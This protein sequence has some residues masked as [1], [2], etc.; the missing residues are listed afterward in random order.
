M[1]QSLSKL[2][3]HLV[4]ST[5]Y[6]MAWLDRAIRYRVHA[7]L[8]SVL[9][10]LASPWVVVGGVEDHVHALFD[11]GK[12]TTPVTFVEIA[13]RESSKY[14][15]TLGRKYSEFS[16]QRGYGM[17]S[18]S[19]FH[20]DRVEAYV[21]SQEAHHRLQS[22]QDEYRM[23]LRAHQIEFDERFVW[24]LPVSLSLTSRCADNHLRG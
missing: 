11:V 8:A 3:V 14:V 6:R 16:W 20:R 2:Y 13:K 4:F 22:F 10:D 15:K 12:Q 18:V 17:F 19:P 7:C 24:D 21:R 9:R 5:K 1:P 23:M